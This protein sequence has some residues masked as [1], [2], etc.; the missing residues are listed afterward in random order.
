MSL[1]EGGN[2]K[3]SIHDFE[4]F[5]TVEWDKHCTEMGHTETGTAPCIICGAAITLDK[6]PYVPRAANRTLKII[7]KSCKESLT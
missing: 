1:H 5:D 3:C 4:T 7:C 6:H 2:Y